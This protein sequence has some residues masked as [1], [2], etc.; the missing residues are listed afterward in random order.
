MNRSFVAAAVLTASVLAV[1]GCA[2]STAPDRNTGGITAPS[3]AGTQTYLRA[4][5]T[6]QTLQMTGV[7]GDVWTHRLTDEVL[8]PL[9][10][11]IANEPTNP[12]FNGKRGQMTLALGSGNE[13][14]AERYFRAS[15]NQNQDWVPGWLGL[16]EVERRRGNFAGAEQYLNSADA[17]LASLRAAHDKLKNPDK[18]VTIYGITIWSPPTD[19]PGDPGPTRAERIGRMVAYAFA[20][21]AWY[22]ESGDLFATWG[23]RQRDVDP[24][25][26]FRRLQ[27]RINFAR[28][29]VGID[30]KDSIDKLLAA[31]DAAVFRY[32][33]DYVPAKLEK[34][35]LLVAQREYKGAESLL[36]PLVDATNP[37]FAMNPDILL[38]TGSVYLAWFEDPIGL[39]ADRR[40]QVIELADGA[41][42][43]TIQHVNRAH[44]PTRLAWANT[45][46][47]YAEVYGD[48]VSLD[49]GRQLVEL[50]RDDTSVSSD[51]KAA[52]SARLTKVQAKLSAGGGR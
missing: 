35:R 37:A 28:I 4:C 29:Q 1:G 24:R 22:I 3:Q 44:G 41:L 42:A 34:A 52:L 5:Q 30:R 48:L 49:R 36:R 40:Q 10:A 33:P 20:D 26:V 51:D 23:D 21:D 45:K 6:Y 39:D 15:L 16:A 47:S 31:F 9:D 17:A 11:A 18:P 43:R 14:L 7:C 27:A 12:L 25:Q 19:A 32:D 38:R 50:L 46:L 8:R 2:G 13:G